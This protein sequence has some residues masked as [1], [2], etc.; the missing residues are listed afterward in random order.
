MIAKGLNLKRK[1][2]YLKSRDLKSLPFTRDGSKQRI[3]E[4]LAIH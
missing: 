4:T 2:A 3:V 1:Q